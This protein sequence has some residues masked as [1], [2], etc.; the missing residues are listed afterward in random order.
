MLG[1]HPQTL[2]R[3]ER[4]GL[5]PVSWTPGGE[6]RFLVSDVQAFARAHQ[7]RPRDTTEAASE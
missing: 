7:P 4:E 6:R 2:R 5:I 3:W 1:V